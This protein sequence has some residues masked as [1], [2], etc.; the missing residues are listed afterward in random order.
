MVDI[1]PSSAS[2]PKVGHEFDV[3]EFLLLMVA[4]SVIAFKQSIRGPLLLVVE[5]KWTLFR[6]PDKFL[7]K[8][9]NSISIIDLS[10]PHDN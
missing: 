9:R 2:Q 5:S 10:S 6:S 8:F 7:R 4:V 3:D 1:P